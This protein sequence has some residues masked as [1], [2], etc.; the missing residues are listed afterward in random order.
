MKKTF[1]PFLI[2][3]SVVFW[4]NST[5]TSPRRVYHPPPLE[6]ARFDYSL[7][8]MAKCSDIAGI[9]VV[10]EGE[11]PIPTPE[12]LLE[13]TGYFV[14]RMIHPFI[15]CESNQEIRVRQ[16]YR[17]PVAIPAQED[18]SPE[19]YQK[20]W[21]QLEWYNECVPTSQARIVLGVSLVPVSPKNETKN[22]N[23]PPLEIKKHGSNP[24]SDDVYY[25]RFGDSGWWYDTVEN[26]DFTKLF[27]N[28]LTCVRTSRS[29]TNYYEL[30]RANLG[31]ENVHIRDSI[32]LDLKDFCNSAS[33]EQSQYM[34]DDPEFLD[35]YKKHLRPPSQKIPPVEKTEEEIMSEDDIEI[36]EDD[37]FLFNRY[38]E[39]DW[40]SF[41]EE[42]KENF[43][44]LEEYDG[45]NRYSLGYLAKNADV[46]GIGIIFE[47]ASPI[48]N[49]EK[50]KQ[51]C[52]MK[53]A[54]L[55]RELDLINLLLP[56]ERGEKI[57]NLM[58][59][60]K[61]QDMWY[62]WW[63]NSLR[64][65]PCDYPLEVQ[66]EAGYAIIRVEIPF[67]GCS[68]GDEIRI[69]QTEPFCIKPSQELK[70][71]NPKAYK[72]AM[73]DWVDDIKYFPT[74]HARIVFN[75][76]YYEYD[77]DLLVNWNVKHEQLTHKL[78]WSLGTLVAKLSDKPV[79][80]LPPSVFENPIYVF[81]ELHN[82]ES[83]WNFCDGTELLTTQFSNII[84][85]VR[86]NRDWK[87]Y[88]ELCR[89]GLSSP[90]YRVRRDAKTD[91]LH[92]MES[93]TRKNHLYMWNDP[94]LP[95]S[96]KRDIYNPTSITTK[97]I[98]TP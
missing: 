5:L 96:F 33:D 57:A 91:L 82:K 86:I 35:E 92:L 20:Q 75:M 11:P 77:Y 26:Q 37:E 93:T 87:A 72:K 9:G 84:Q 55:R 62:H 67:V 74:N 17:P 22:W 45:C 81:S 64:F 23:V 10:M 21:R 69:E 31:S 68:Q 18:L 7:G 89:D 66:D 63:D 29:W 61:W 71:T 70:Q 54:E 73:E 83:W 14:V 60:D 6:L 88:Y 53:I 95:Q 97:W 80:P 42:K 56:E 28:L 3:A 39:D 52:E 13:Q 65:H 59:E 19:E 50:R 25:E 30:C 24:D 40:K 90:S 78:E 41:F 76:S 94:L 36:M 38:F 98:I 58:N 16:R 49:N 27:T 15:G 85:A 43:F 4:S 32:K 34:R 44:Y 1:L 2:Y 48:N 79:R 47:G 12:V 51:Y 46:A 8:V